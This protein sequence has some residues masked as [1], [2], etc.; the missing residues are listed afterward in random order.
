MTMI[1]GIVTLMATASG[2]MKV[3]VQ[4]RFQRAVK[5]RVGQ[6]FEVIDMFLECGVVNQ[7]V[8][9]AQ[10]LRGAFNGFCTEFRISDITGS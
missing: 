3:A 5:M 9:V 10:L 8:E 4:I 1:V 6:I 7:Y 2:H